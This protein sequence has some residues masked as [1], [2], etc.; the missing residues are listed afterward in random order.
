MKDAV[1]RDLLNPVATQN[2]E[3]DRLK[4]DLP[5]RI[6]D[7][8]DEVLKKQTTDDEKK[9]IVRKT[10]YPIVGDARWKA[11]DAPLNIWEIDKI[12]DKLEKLTG[13]ELDEMVKDSVQRR[14]YWDILAP[15]NLVRPGDVTAA[16][17]ETMGDL[18]VTIDDLKG[19]LLARLDAAIAPDVRPQGLHRRR[20]R[21]ERQARHR[22]EAARDR[23]NPVHARPGREARP[24]REAH[25]EGHRAGSDDQR[26][27]RIH[28]CDDR[29]RRR[30]S[31]SGKPAGPGHSRRSRRRRHQIGQGA[32]HADRGFHRSL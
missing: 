23:A 20:L 32:D 1:F 2:E 24:Q 14:I 7:A 21:Q 5:K 26:A 30:G 19:Y 6:A 4:L 9:A 11:K 16:Q 13:A 3:I 12:N 25:Q 27:L 22:R 29:I 10:L 31:S 28:Q 15:L 18:N 17:I 8:A